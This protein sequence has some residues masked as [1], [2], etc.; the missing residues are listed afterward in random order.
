MNFSRVGYIFLTSWGL[1]WGGSLDFGA[2]QTFESNS[3]LILGSEANRS[4]SIRIGDLDADGDLD[5]VVAN[6]RHWPDQ[7]YV[8]L[9]QGRAR[10]NVMRPLGSDRSTTYA[11]ELADFDGDGDLDIATGNDMAPCQIFL[12][13]GDAQFSLQGSFGDVSSVRSLTVADIDLDGDQDILVTCRG[14]S[15]RIY[16]NDGSAKFDQSI[17]FGTK[18]DSTIDV[19]VG[20]VDGDGDLD[21]VLANRDGQPNAWL[22]NDGKLNFD[23]TRTFGHAQSQT[24]AVAVGD[25]DGNGILDWAIGNIGQSNQLFLG[26]GKGGV[27]KAIDFGEVDSK[28]YCLAAFDMDRDGDLD[29]IAGNAGQANAVYLNEGRSQSFRE[30]VFGDPLHLTYGLSVGDL[31]S[32]GTPDIALANSDAPNQVFLGRLDRRNISASGMLEDIERAMPS[33]S[34]D[35][36]ERAEYR[37]HDWPA[38]RGLGGRGVAEGFSLPVDWNADPEAGDLKNVLWQIQ[39]PGLGHSSPVVVEDKVFLLTAVSQNGKAPLEIEAGGQPTAADDNETQDWLLLCYDKAKGRELWRQTLRQG[40]PGATRHSKATHAN[41]SVCVSGQK[42]ITFLGSEGLYCHDLNGKE[43]WKQD[44]GVINI[45]KY[46]IGWG[47][48]SS[49]AVDTDRIVLVCDDPENPF[50][51]ARRLS[52]GEEIWRTSRRDVCE[53]SWGTPLIHHQETPQVIVNGWPWIV[54]YRLGDG[55]ELWRIQ[56]GGDNPIPSPFEAHGLIYITNAHGGP[57]PIHAIRPNAHGALEV[58][59]DDPF[60]AWSVEKGGS[61]MSTPV[62]YEDQIYLGNSN[63]ILRSFHATTGEK[64]FEQRLGDRAGVIASLVAGD[65]KIYC[66]SENGNVYVLQHGPDMN[67]I[68]ENSMGEPCLATPAISEGVLFIRTTSQLTAI[69]QIP[70]E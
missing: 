24:R 39:I 43:L 67:V 3:R 42:V 18:R 16:L 51:T 52:D 57:S 47:F 37:T 65:G 56:G 12:N 32:D 70:K 17:E 30:V 29:L 2:A 49:P 8:F 34:A 26:D 31:D 59:G 41:T 15:N 28:T 50:V 7:N 4:A 5:V 36:R 61:Y 60:I 38:F 55:E 63:G 20:D 64:I 11:C 23:Q 10:F 22:I 69:Q 62:V 54:A 53:R 9:N 48:A 46:G 33:G 44:L 68:A 13:D 6:G 25:F 19:E 40:K 66:A 14:R 21:L 58:T 45:S 35:F 27:A 1:M